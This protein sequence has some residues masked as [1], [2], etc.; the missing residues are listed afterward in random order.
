MGLFYKVPDD[1]TGLNDHVSTLLIVMAG[2]GSAGMMQELRSEVTVEWRSTMAR[3]RAQ[4]RDEDVRR[5]EKYVKR[6]AGFM[7]NA[8]YNHVFL[9]WIKGLR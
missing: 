9:P 6:F 8:H 1:L 4:G 7:D 5:Y 3:L 2:G